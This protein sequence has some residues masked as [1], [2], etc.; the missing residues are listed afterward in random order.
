[1]RCFITYRQTSY[2]IAQQILGGTAATCHAWSQPGAR[3]NMKSVQWEIS[4]TVL[5]TAE[6]ALKAYHVVSPAD[7]AFGL[8]RPREPEAFR[9]FLLLI[10]A[11]ESLSAPATEPLAPARTSSSSLTDTLVLCISPEYDEGRGDVRLSV[12]G[13]G[14]LDFRACLVNESLFSICLSSCAP[15]GR[16]ERLSSIDDDGVN[17]ADKLF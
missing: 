2:S 10:C 12:T 8:R 16:A 14:A 7:A 4:N 6:L 5:Y 9:N 3:H 13:T 15:L 11:S 17:G 1:M